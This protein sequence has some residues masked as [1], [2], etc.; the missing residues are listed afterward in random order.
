MIEDRSITLLRAAEQLLEAQN[1]SGMVLN[2]LTETVFYDGTN[3]DG[4][5]LLNDI[6]VYLDEVQPGRKEG[7]SMNDSIIKREDGVIFRPGDFVRHFKW[8]TLSE[9]EKRSNFY[10]YV[11]A[12]L[13]RHTET[14]EY[15]V[16][17]KPLYNCT[18]LDADFAARP[19]SMFLSEVD[20]EKYPDIKQKYRFERWCDCVGEK[21]E[22]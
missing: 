2:L 3:C 10:V 12:G 18:G 1:S 5:C 22:V 15:L 19:L 9:E 16:I 6:S 11:V 4:Y 21:K 20:H 13:S 14:G 7:K 17:Y 8:E